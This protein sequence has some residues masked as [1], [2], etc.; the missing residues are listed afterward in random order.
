MSRELSRRQLVVGATA[1]AASACSGRKGAPVVSQA[2]TPPSGGLPSIYL[3]HGGGPWTI[4]ENMRSGHEELDAYLKGLAATL[5]EQPK[6]VLCV[7]A[8]WEAAK[9]TVQT[10]SSPP[11]L[12]DY[13]GFPPESYEFVWPAPG[14]PE[15]AAMVTDH[16]KSAGLSFGEDPERGFDHGAFVPLMRVD[17]KAATPTF[18]LSLIEGLDPL[19]HIEVGKALAPLREQGVL[20]LGSG[21]SY[22]NMRGFMQA[23]RSRDAAAMVQDDSKRFD[24]WLAETMALEPSARE[25][26]LVEWA[27][28]PGGRESHPRE[29]HL[30]PLMVNL[31]AGLEA[32]ASI[33]FQANV[34]GAHVSAVH[35]G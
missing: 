32:E 26:R 19:A 24:D 3:P 33:A 12:Y 17:P 25:T 31:G 29:E 34:V 35:F 27:K 16:L 30:L 13:Y 18:Q 5:P 9:P 10:S 1:V 8:H 6:A 4:V 28:A 2:Q 7:S 21:M 23:M 15:V 11:M 14:S 20:I 22:H